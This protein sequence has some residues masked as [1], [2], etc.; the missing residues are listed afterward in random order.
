MTSS[1]TTVVSTIARD[2][3][4]HAERAFSGQPHGGGKLAEHKAYLIRYHGF[5]YRGEGFQRSEKDVGVWRTTDVV[6]EAA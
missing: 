2:T 3:Q 1:L 5:F 6:Y 4:R